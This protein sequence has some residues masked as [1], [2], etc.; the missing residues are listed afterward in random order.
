MGLRENLMRVLDWG[1]SLAKYDT[2][3]FECGGESL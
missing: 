1:F 2:T 3:I